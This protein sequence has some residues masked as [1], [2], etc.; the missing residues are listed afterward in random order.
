MNILKNVLIIYKIKIKTCFSKESL[1]KISEELK[2]PT[3]GSKQNYG[4]ILE[5]ILV[6]NVMKN[7]VG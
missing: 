6:I 3:K 4:I 5:N 7:H 1:I 2:L